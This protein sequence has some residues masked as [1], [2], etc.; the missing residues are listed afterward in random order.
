MTYLRLSGKRVGLIIN[1]D[2]TKLMSSVV[3][4]AV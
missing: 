2:V 1:F 4:R 3:R